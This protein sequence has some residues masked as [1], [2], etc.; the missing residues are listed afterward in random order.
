MKQSKEQRRNRLIKS[1][2]QK[3]YSAN[4]IQ[5]MLR[6][7]GL[8]LRRKELLRRVRE[9][10]KV[11][12]RG[13]GAKYVPVKYRRPAER[14]AVQPAKAVAV[15]GLVYGESKRVQMYGSGRDLYKAMVLVS[16]HP[17][18]KKFLTADASRI[19][20]SPSEYLDLDEEWDRHPEVSS[21]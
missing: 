1:Y 2:A 20:L 14:K 15:Y 3:G 13:T 21:R 16:R 4:R 6:Q 18:R 7:K 5:K 9:V 10:K 19:A 12:P 8:G 11:K 17:P